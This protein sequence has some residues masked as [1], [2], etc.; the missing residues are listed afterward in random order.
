MD[1]NFNVL[2]NQSAKWTYMDLE[3]VNNDSTKKFNLFSA[4]Q[5][6]I[7]INPR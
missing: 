6:G 4:H 5:G 2:P 3:V 1:S 7:Q